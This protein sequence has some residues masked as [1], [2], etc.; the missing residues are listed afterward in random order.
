M[1]QIILDNIISEKAV[2]QSTTG[3][4]VI[5]VAPKASRPEIKKQIEKL[6]KVKVKKINSLNYPA[7]S[8]NFRRI[9]GKTK[10]TKRMIITLV[11]GQKIKEFEFDTKEEKE[12][13]KEKK[14]KK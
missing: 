1:N 6:F 7:K 12:N 8:K 3:K 11:P 5:E 4:Y 2:G 14:K 9:P 10:A 13:K